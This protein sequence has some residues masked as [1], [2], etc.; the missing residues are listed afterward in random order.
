MAVVTIDKL[1][2]VYDRGHAPAADNVSLD[3][4]HGEFMVLLGPR[5]AARRR[6]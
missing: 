5:A 6:R 1:T 2:K 4:A 3:I